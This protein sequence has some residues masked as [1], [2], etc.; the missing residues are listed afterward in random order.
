[1]KKESITFLLRELIKILYTKAG[2]QLEK[3]N[4]TFQQYQA[5]IL[6]HY[7]NALSMS[8]IKNKLLI[9]RPGATALIDKLV[10]KR[11]IKRDYSLEDRRR[12]IIASTPK[13]E[14]VLAKLLMGHE[15]FAKDMAKR[16][17]K[18]GLRTV[19]QALKTLLDF[20]NTHTDN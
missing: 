19:E 8:E 1:M 14:K 7:D 18:D 20:L 13:G 10:K 12:V 9:S 6:L 15:K 17:G 3:H 2:K 16:I 5:L 4:L 11:L